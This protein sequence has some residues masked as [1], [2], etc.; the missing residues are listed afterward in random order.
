MCVCGDGEVRADCEHTR[1]IA[2]Y[3]RG[4]W[5]WGDGTLPKDHELNHLLQSCAAYGS[6]VFD[7]GEL[8]HIKHCWCWGGRCGCRRERRCGCATRHES[9]GRTRVYVLARSRI[10]VWCGTCHQRLCVYVFVCACVC[11][12]VLRVRVFLSMCVRVCVR[13]S[14]CGDTKCLLAQS[15][16]CV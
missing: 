7:L 10:C 16:V 2:R 9:V 4:R 11:A 6:S 13:A 1:L 15:R 14:V 8:A 3:L 12:L 5:P